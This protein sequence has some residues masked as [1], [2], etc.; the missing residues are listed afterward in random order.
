MRCTPSSTIDVPDTATPTLRRPRLLRLLDDAAR[1]LVAVVAPAG[2]GKTRLLADWVATPPVVPTAWVVLDRAHTA[3]DM[4]AALATA[5]ERAAPARHPVGRVA[6]SWSG[7]RWTD[8]RETAFADELLDAAARRRPPCAWSSTTPTTSAP[9]RGAGSPCWPG[10]ATPASGWPW[11]HA[12]TP[13]CRW[14]GCASK[15]GCVSCARPSSA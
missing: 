5:L 14:P 13:T 10:T 11:L 15:D 7:S 3:A 2:F 1:P 8:D 12:P 6:R 9:T 4:W